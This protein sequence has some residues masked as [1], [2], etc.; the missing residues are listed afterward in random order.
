M[1]GSSAFLERGF[2]TY[3]NRSKVEELGVDPAVLE[4]EGAVSE[5]VARAM[6]EGARRVAG[7][8]IG[9][10][11]TG[12]AGPDGGTPEKPVGLVFVALAG[13]AGD[14]VRRL[15]LFSQRERVRNHS[16]QIALE[17][18]RRGLLGLPAL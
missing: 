7:T 1:P 15:R 8:S 5:A 18:L 13:A 4:A 14:T 16:V 2:V 3:S 6:A 10:G 9:V 11:I 12:I 17:M